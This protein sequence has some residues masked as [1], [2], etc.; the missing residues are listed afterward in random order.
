MSVNSTDAFSG[1]YV[2]SG[3]A[4]EFPFTF[5]TK[6]RDE[7]R[8]TAD[9]VVVDPTSYTVTL[10]S[11]GTGKVNATL[12]AGAQ[13]YVE[14]DPSFEQEAQFS[15][16]APYFPDALN[17]HLDRAA[18]RDIVLADQLSRAPVLPRNAT[19]Q[20]GLYLFV[21][22]DGK[23]AFAPGV[24]GVAGPAAAFRSTLAA[25]KAASISDGQSTYDGGIW[26][27]TSGN[28]VGQADDKTI[29]KADGVSLLTGAWVRALDPTARTPE[30][31][32]NDT[33]A[34]QRAINAASA[35]GV[36]LVLTAASVYTVTAT[37][38]VPATGVT[39]QGNGA[40]ITALS[41]AALVGG[42]LRG[43]NASNVRIENV[44]FD[45]NGDANGA[46]YCVWLTGGTGHLL[47]KNTFRN[48]RQAGVWMDEAAGVVSRSTS[49]NCGRATSV[50]GG[51]ATNN[52]GIMATSTTVAG[53]RNL[54][55]VGNIV[56]NA[57][58]KGITLYQADP[59]V[60][61]GVEI[62][63][64]TATGCGSGGIY[65]GVLPG[66]ARLKNIIINDNQAS[67]NY[68]NFDINDIDGLVMNGVAS[69]A[70]SN[71]GTA[72]PVG[73]AAQGVILNNLK[74]GIVTGLSDTESA[75]GGLRVSNSTG[76]VVRAPKIVRPNAA[77]VGFA[78]AVEILAATGC[79]VVDISAIDD[80]STPTM[81]HVFVE[82]GAS[83]SNTVSV[84][85]GVGA[86]NAPIVL[87]AS[88]LFEITSGRRRGIGVLAPQNTLHIAGG[89]TQNEQGLLL[90]NGANQNVGLPTDT[91][92]LVITGPT[93]VYSIGGI[94]G[95]HAGREID[96]FNYTSFALT[97]TH[98]SAGSSAGNRFTLPSSTDL[99]IP[100]FGRV[101]LRY[102]ALAG[103]VWTAK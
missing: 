101:R 7:V 77:G 4:Q 53:L 103:N 49:E 64:N 27:W 55:T 79:Q 102:S 12:T 81:T 56:R 48:S 35:A 97:L 63:G 43:V 58:R 28:Y 20:Q 67:G 16:F 36:P 3:A 73:T 87:G 57:W 33:T 92:V 76:T 38:S 95:G 31:Y 88:T 82:Q 84:L 1:P 89:V 71:P 23:W 22:L 47:D 75:T 32:G 19:G 8:V 42:I 100:S 13:V 6:S 94:A 40:T 85:R 41:G 61:D 9:G 72:N 26:F 78:P 66:S 93:A 91:G 51:T 83:D 80:R 90:A 74:G 54:K 50:G 2:A 46:D 45:A 34:L 62:S 11:D 52:H 65:T 98:Q 10:E 59:G 68:A 37:L 25:L 69:V 70:S 60:V 30:T 14:S 21:G 86:L 18:I 39:I 44:V 17:P 99:V 5:V 15:R 24:P 96:L 29:V